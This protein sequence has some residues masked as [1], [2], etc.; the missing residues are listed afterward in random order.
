MVVGEVVKTVRSAWDTIDDDRVEVDNPRKFHNK[1]W[2]RRLLGLLVDG[3]E[4]EVSSEA[5]VSEKTPSLFLNDARDHHAERHCRYREG[6]VHVL[7]TTQPTCPS[8]QQ[9]LVLL[10]QQLCCTIVVVSGAT[11]AHPAV[12]VVHPGSTIA[13][14]QEA[15]GELQPRVQGIRVS[16]KSLPCVQMSQMA[17][18]AGRRFTS[19]PQPVVT[20]NRKRKRQDD[21]P[22]ARFLSE[23]IGGTTRLHNYGNDRQKQL[24]A[25]V[26]EKCGGKFTK[27]LQGT[28]ARNRCAGIIVCANCYAHHRR[29]GHFRVKEDA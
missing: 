2:A 1:E 25:P 9:W 10:A 4:V 11:T 3:M 29:H 16:M 6:H 26:C 8:C 28:P 15:G 22:V 7:L 17:R 5:D 13:D 18:N 14:E 24:F 21:D 23:G 19:R 20:R 27:T 12:F